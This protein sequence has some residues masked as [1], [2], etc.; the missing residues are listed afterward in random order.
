MA[1]G[2]KNNGGHSTKGF[3]GRKPKD[4]EKRIRDLTSPY[5]DGA[6]QSVVSIMENAEKESDK[7]A[8]AKLLLAYHFGNPSQSID[9]STLGEKITNII[10]LGSGNKP[11]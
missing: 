4:E 7:L 6:I 11:E 8:A 1:D 2:R 3:A 10:S 9:H 5:V